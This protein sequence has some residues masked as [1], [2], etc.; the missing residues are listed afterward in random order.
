MWNC[1]WHFSR[2]PLDT[3]PEWFSKNGLGHVIQSQAGNIHL[4]IKCVGN[5]TLSIALR[6]NDVRNSTNERLPFWIYYKEL[7]VNGE[8]QLNSI[9]TVWHDK[10]Y[11]FKKSVK[12]GEIVTFDIKWSPDDKSI[13]V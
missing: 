12:D 2:L 11:I 3:T 5:G 13:T 10:P 1:S 8:E 6:G 9:Y 4:C 7:S